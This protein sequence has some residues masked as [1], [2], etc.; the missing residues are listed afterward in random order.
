M[1][2]SAIRKIF[3]SEN[4]S[5]LTHAKLQAFDCGYHAMSFNGLIYIRIDVQK[6]KWVR[7]CFNI[8]DFSTGGNL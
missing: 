1:Y 4:A 5:G 6:N 3:T 2:A 7:T 8:S